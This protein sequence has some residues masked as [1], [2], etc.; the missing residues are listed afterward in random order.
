MLV[1]RVAGVPLPAATAAEADVDGAP[2]LP[3]LLIMAGA[4]DGDG[5]PK[6]LA[7]TAPPGTTRGAFL[8]A[9]RL[10]GVH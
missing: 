9:R 4:D 6:Y 10:G 3:P 5:S 7:I 8:S 2:P 1:F